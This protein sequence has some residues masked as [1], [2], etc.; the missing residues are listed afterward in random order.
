MRKR[1]KLIH[2]KA[3]KNSS[4]LIKPCDERKLKYISNY[5]D[6]VGRYKINNPVL[7][8]LC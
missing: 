3:K 7:C 2:S 1:G 5:R 6:W 8:I 4:K